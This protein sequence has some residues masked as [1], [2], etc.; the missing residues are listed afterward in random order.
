MKKVIFKICIVLIAIL[1]FFSVVYGITYSKETNRVL[2]NVKREKLAYEEVEE[3]FIGNYIGEKSQIVNAKSENLLNYLQLSLD[4]VENISV[5][6]KDNLKSNRVIANNHQIDLDE[7]GNITKIINYNDFSTV[8]KDRRIYD[9]NETLEDIKYKYNDK[10]LIQPIIDEIYNNLE[11][12]QYELVSC[13][14]MLDG[15]WSIVWNKVMENNIVNPFDVVVVSV[16]AKDG[17]IITFNR[18]CI[19]PEC[20]INMIN[21]EDA[22]KFAEPV[23]KKVEK[24]DKVTTQLTVVKPNFFWEEGGPYEEADFIR[25]AWKIILDGNIFIDVDAETGEIL[26]GDITQSDGARVMCTVPAFY[27]TAVRTNLAAEA[28]ARLGY[29]QPAWCQPWNDWVVKTDITWLITHP[30][31]YGLFLS[32]HGPAQNWTPGNRY[33]TDS[34]EWTLFPSEISGNW[35]FVILDACCSINYTDFADAFHANGYA[36]RCCVGWNVEIGTR[37][38]HEFW[39][40]FS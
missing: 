14:D 21:E 20:N 11:L 30:E 16:D 31:L 22:I 24:Y 15:T 37:T 35:H 10:S 25:I 4:G 5:I 29:Y 2:D 26:G 13:H 19:T 6:Q 33:L 12:E 1:A 18:N 40:R 36:G 28:F 23:I 38:A 7:N 17:S 3:K 32:C 27:N 34:R 9:E 8:D 39:K